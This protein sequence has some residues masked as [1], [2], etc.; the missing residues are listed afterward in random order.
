[1]KRRAFLLGGAATAMS[2]RL[3][4]AAELPYLSSAALAQVAHDPDYLIELYR[5]AEKPFMADLPPDFSVL[6][7]SMRKLAFASLVA[8]MM[9]PYGNSNPLTLA[10]CLA[11]PDLNCD[12]YCVFTY[13][14]YR[15]LQPSGG[16]EPAM[17]GWNGGTIGNHAQMQVSHDGYHL[18]LD[19][20]IGFLA[21][22]L[23]LSGLCRGYG[24]LKGRYISFFDHGKNKNNVVELNRRVSTAIINATTL[25]ENILYYFP[26]VSAYL[27]ATGSLYW[28]T[29]QSWRI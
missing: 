22:D 19:P 28:A 26:S 1:M 20:T 13:F 9:K 16:A 10:D 11:A 29:P 12:N 27:G 15:V 21:R 6:S 7:E 3:A 17:L 14:L 8:F 2:F 25:A 23:T 24:P 18:L 5:D 4:S